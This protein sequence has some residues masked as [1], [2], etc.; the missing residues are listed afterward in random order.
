MF[1][2]FVVVNIMII[3]SLLIYFLSGYFY[4]H[5]YPVSL[6]LSYIIHTFYYVYTYTCLFQ[7]GFHVFLSP[8]PFFIIVIIHLCN[9]LYMRFTSTLFIIIIY[10]FPYIL[11]V[12]FRKK[13]IRDIVVCDCFFVKCIKNFLNFLTLTSY[14]LLNAQNN[15]KIF[16]IKILYDA[17]HT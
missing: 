5:L 7:L 3:T 11:N 15:L 4:F 2:I 10:L 8:T 9:V 6:N 17:Y 1:T 16:S 12:C 14:F 13:E